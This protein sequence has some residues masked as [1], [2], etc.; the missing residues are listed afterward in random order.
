MALE[1][2]RLRVSHEDARTIGA[3][4]MLVCVDVEDSKFKEYICKQGRPKAKAKAKKGSSGMAGIPYELGYWIQLLMLQKACFFI[5]S[6]LKRTFARN[7]SISI[8][9]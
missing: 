6:D 7:L 9:S 4:S 3:V 1:L 5:S 8:S 2:W